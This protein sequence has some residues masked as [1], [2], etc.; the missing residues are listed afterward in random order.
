MENFPWTRLAHAALPADT[1][2][3]FDRTL[4]KA[5]PPDLARKIL[6]D[7]TFGGAYQ[8]PDDAMLALW[9]IGVEETRELLEGPW[10]TRS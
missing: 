2:P 9:R 6:G 7:G 1:K 3:A 10:P 5:S 4:V 8:M